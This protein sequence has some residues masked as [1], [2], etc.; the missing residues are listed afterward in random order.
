MFLSF[1]EDVRLQCFDD[2]EDG[3]LKYEGKID[4]ANGLNGCETHLGFDA[5]ACRSVRR[6]TDQKKC[7]VG[8]GKLQQAN[9][10]RMENIEIAM[11]EDQ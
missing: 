7:A 4:D 2:V 8:F 11:D 9:M 1:Y 5:G 10:P 3:V 6:D